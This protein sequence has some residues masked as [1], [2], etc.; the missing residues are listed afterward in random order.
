MPTRRELKHRRILVVED[1]AMIAMDLEALLRQSGC[2]VVGPVASLRE[3]LRAVAEEA[4]DAA[5][6]DINL[7]EEKALAVADALAGSGVPFVFVTGYGPEIL[8]VRHRGR[9]VT[10]K[11]YRPERLLRLLV[12]AM[13]RAR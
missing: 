11:P 10:T 3:A 12:E 8:P 9:P 4:L 6:L 1:E 5:V 2:E 13:G 7:G